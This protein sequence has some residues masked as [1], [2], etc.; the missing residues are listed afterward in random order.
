MRRS[1]E[2]FDEHHLPRIAQLVQRTNQFN[3]TTIRHSAEELRE[4]ADDP[5]YLPYYVTLKDRFGDSGL[6][7]VVIGKRDGDGLDIV[8]WLMSCRVA[9]RRL[10]EF[11]LDELVAAAR[12]AGIAV[13]RGRYVPTKKNG[14]VAG[15][16][17]RL[18]FRL[19]EELAD[20]STRWS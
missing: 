7:S 3:L 13:L 18:G 11:V 8:S 2:P 5:E 9:S 12:E 17:A 4:F 20:G 6:I 14:L 1:F 16:Y 19:T 10:E 15:H